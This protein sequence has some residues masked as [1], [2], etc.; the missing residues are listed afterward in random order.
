MNWKKVKL[1]DVANTGSGGTPSRTNIDRYFGG[2]IPWVKS[3]ELKSNL[4]LNTEEYINDLAIRESSAKVIP[5]DSILVALY[6]ATVGNTAI[7]GVD[8]ATNQAVCYIV[9]KMNHVLNKYIFYLLK[10]RLNELLSMR[11]GGAQPNI[12]QQVIKDISFFLPSI[13]EQEQI[14]EI[15]DKANEIKMKKIKAIEKSEKIITSLF[16]KMFG[17]PIVLL[18]DTN[19]I[20]LIDFNIDIQNGFACGNKDVKD[21][22]SHLRMNNISDLG[23][24]N[25]DLVRTV[26]LSYKLSMYLYQNYLFYLVKEFFHQTTI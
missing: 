22:I 15:L 3:G 11:V 23:I 10:S 17:D 20:N 21:G 1:S 25:L 19:S 8:A 24:L 7:L 26:P 2:N 6:G 4:I 12:S 14:V 16:Y 13:S 18:N 9:P 5:K